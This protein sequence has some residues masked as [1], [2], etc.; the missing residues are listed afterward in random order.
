[1]PDP[2]QYWVLVQE[3]RESLLSLVDEA[4][5]F[6]VRLPEIERLYDRRYR[7]W[8]PGERKHGKAH[9]VK[10]RHDGELDRFYREEFRPYTDSVRAVFDKLTTVLPEQE[11]E[12]LRR[13]VAPSRVT[14][15]CEAVKHAFQR[16]D[17][18]WDS[19]PDSPGVSGSMSSRRKYGPTPKTDRHRA[20]ANAV[21]GHGDD[22]RHQ[23]NI[24]HTIATELDRLKIPISSAWKKWKPAAPNTWERA[25]EYGS[26]KVRKTIAYSLKMAQR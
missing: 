5:R 1:M 19:R 20:I 25:V 18:F 6:L 2:E 4:E 13:Q 3:C 15:T 24:L 8:Y 23:E 16:V 10:E 17:E 12:D 9:L 7:A 26:D 21:N 22:W 14:A 11:V